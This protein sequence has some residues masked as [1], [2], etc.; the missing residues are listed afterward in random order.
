[1]PSYAKLHVFACW[2]RSSLTSFKRWTL[3]SVIRRHCMSCN[4]PAAALH[5]L[6]Q[7]CVKENECFW[8]CVVR[9]S[10][11]VAHNI[12]RLMHETQK[13]VLQLPQ[14]WCETS[15]T[16]CW[17]IFL[18]RF[19]Y[20]IKFFKKFFQEHYQNVICLDPDQD[21]QSGS[22]PGRVVQS[23]MCLTLDMCLTADPGFASSIP[24]VSHTLWRLIMK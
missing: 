24:A 11:G 16:A 6:Q 1:M 3:T 10:Y 22:K 4:S 12:L 20:R 9:Q 15:L 21:R 5:A 17:P 8:R 19:F 23:V 2:S 7:S 18:C 13:F 14:G